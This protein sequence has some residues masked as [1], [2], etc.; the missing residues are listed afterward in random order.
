ME[1]E[2]FQISSADG[3]VAIC[4][5]PRD[6]KKKKRKKVIASIGPSVSFS[7]TGVSDQINT[8]LESEWYH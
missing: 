2:E 5:K 6:V 3:E 7:F 8:E 4:I 1:R